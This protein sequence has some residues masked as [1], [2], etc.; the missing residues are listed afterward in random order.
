VRYNNNTAAQVLKVYGM[1]KVK[2]NVFNAQI[3]KKG[4]IRINVVNITIKINIVNSFVAGDFK[5]IFIIQLYHLYYIKSIKNFLTFLIFI[6]IILL[7]SYL[8]FLSTLKF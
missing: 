2:N 7:Y 5:F 8:A 4:E 3:T 1:S 6:F